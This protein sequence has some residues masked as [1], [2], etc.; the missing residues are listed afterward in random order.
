MRMLM[1]ISMPNE[2]FNTLVREGRATQTMERLLGAMK[3]EAAFFAEMNGE[4]TG[5][6]VVEV[7][8]AHDIPRLAEPFFLTLGAKVSLHPCMTPEDLGKAGL[9]AL[10]S[11]WR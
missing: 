10:G 11:A 8:A 9:D 7:P 6:L 1:K 2:P 4:R 5:I 3:P